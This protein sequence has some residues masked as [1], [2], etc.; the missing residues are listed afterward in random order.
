RPRH[1]GGRPDVRRRARTGPRGRDRGGRRAAR[2]PA[3]QARRPHV[4]P[5]RR[6]LRRVVP[7]VLPRRRLPHR[8]RRRAPRRPR[9]RRLHG[10]GVDEPQPV[11]VL[12]AHPPHDRRGAGARRRVQR[13]GA[14]GGAV[15]HPLP[16][17]HGRGVGG[18]RG[19]VT[20]ATENRVEVDAASTST[21]WVMYWSIQEIAR[22]TGVTSRTLRHYDAVGLLPAVRTTASGP[23]RYDRTALVRLQ[24]ILLL[25]DLG[26]GLGDIAEVLD[27]E[28]DEAAALR[29]HLVTLR[30][31]QDR[32]AR[33]IASVERTVA[34]LERDPD[35]KEDI[36]AQDMLDGF[37]H[38]RYEQEV[39]ER[40]GRDAYQQSDRWWRGLGAEEQAA[41]KAEVAE[42]SSAWAA[43]AEAGT[44]PASDEAQA[45]AA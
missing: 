2:A 9:G 29:R 17:V 4:P 41:V 26:L 25:R 6:L 16:P 30:T 37:D 12:E 43:A 15:P 39:T 24:R 18:A 21:V 20:G 45:L 5:V 35:A 40:W 38:T 28:Q 14:G 27:S 22:L 44:D 34:A 32:L 23:R 3:R 19:G 31:E 7:D 13:G 33:Q 11:R 10:A 1:P 36:M 8:R 42:L